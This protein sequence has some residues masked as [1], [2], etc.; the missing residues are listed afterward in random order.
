MPKIK[1]KHHAKVPID[2]E[3]L[4]AAKDPAQYFKIFTD[5]VK[6]LGLKI[7]RKS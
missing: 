6:K 7:G 5:K 4:K 2:K 3:I 1:V